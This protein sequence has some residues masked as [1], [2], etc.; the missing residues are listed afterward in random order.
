[1]YRSVAIAY[2]P[3][4]QRTPRSAGEVSA[5]PGS[6]RPHRETGCCAWS[7]EELEQH[8]LRD[9][10]EVELVAGEDL[11]QLCRTRVTDVI[12]P[13]DELRS[14][15][16]ATR[17][18]SS[19]SLTPRI[20][21]WIARTSAGSCRSHRFSRD[22]EVQRLR[23]DVGKMYAR[24]SRAGNRRSAPTAMRA[25]RQVLVRDPLPR[26]GKDCRCSRRCRRYE[27]VARYFS[28]SPTVHS[29]SRRRVTRPPES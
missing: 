13:N 26:R 8:G 27:T 25:R 21:S 24:R 5:A 7:A 17:R 19:R 29:R 20:V 16:S 10:Q 18:N 11:L 14:R 3:K 15:A 6:P 1:M 23:R 4:I 12:V 2:A 9:R 28:V 22:V